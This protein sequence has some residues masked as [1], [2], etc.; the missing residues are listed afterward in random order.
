MRKVKLDQ[1]ETGLLESFEAGEWHTVEDSDAK[2]LQYRDYAR[3]T[4]KKDRRI[5]TTQAIRPSSGPRPKKG[6]MGVWRAAK[7]L[8][9]PP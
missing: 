2:V 3:V 7:P 6:E 4:F 5:V 1:E 8:S 9:K